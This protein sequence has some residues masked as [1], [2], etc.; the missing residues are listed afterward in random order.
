[1]DALV[2]KWGAHCRQALHDHYYPGF[3][4]MPSRG[5]RENFYMQVWTRDFVHAALNYYIDELPE[6]FEDSFATLM[7]HQRKDGGLPVRVEREYML[8]KVMPL[9]FRLL[10]RPLFVL[11][12]RLFR[13]RSERPVF[14]GQDFTRSKDT[15]PLMI[16]AAQHYAASSPRGRAFIA[17]QYE[18]LV[19][20]FDYFAKRMDVEDGLVFLPYGAVDWADSIMREGKLGL[21]NTLWVVACMAMHELRTVFVPNEQQRISDVVLEQA[22]ES[23]MRELYCKDGHYFR[24]TVGEERI[25]T[26]ASI[27]GSLFFLDPAESARVQDTLRAR[28]QRR[29]GLRN[30]DPPYPRANIMLPHKLFGHAGYHNAYVWPWV[31]CQN[32]LV[33]I[34]IGT[35]HPDASVRE[36]FKQEAVADL[37]DQAELF[38]RAG[39]A[40]EIFHADDRTPAITFFYRPPKDLLANLATFEGARR[41]LHELGWLADS[42]RGESA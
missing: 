40:Y 36:R 27:V 16:M 14:A 1:M 35:T 10:A 11:I 4:V 31:A 23:L 25:D 5:R 42:R 20:A 15:I 13:G 9:P 18:A 7:R 22:R 32:I 26:I 39:G 29:A 6:A 38:E 30:F 21:I 2:E 12:E 37:V 8:V 34:R 19:R 3:G 28:V 17:D 33:K 24:A 41:K